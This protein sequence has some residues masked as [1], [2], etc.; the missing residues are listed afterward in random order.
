MSNNKNQAVTASAAAPEAPAASTSTM[1]Q[2][3]PAAEAV[4]LV[5]AMKEAFGDTVK[6]EV[7]R[8]LQPLDSA[9]KLQ[10]TVGEAAIK[11]LLAAADNKSG[12]EARKALRAAGDAIVNDAITAGK[13]SGDK[14]EVWAVRPRTG[15]AIIAGV[16]TGMVGVG[17]VAHR[18]GHKS[19]LEEGL[20]AQIKNVYSAG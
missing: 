12:D 7:E 9:S 11:K 6:A 4:V 17:V 2:V 3:I 18:I 13:M 15:Y 5:H 1:L 10:D 14:Y 8:R 16:F 19:G 20:T